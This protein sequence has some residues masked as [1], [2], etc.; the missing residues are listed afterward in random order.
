MAIAAF[1]LAGGKSSRM[2]TDKGLLEYKNKPMIAH[3]IDA[4]EPITKDIS[5]ITGNNDYKK[6]NKPLISD[7]IPEKGPM[8][9]VYTALKRCPGSHALILTCDTPLI[10][11][12]LINILLED[13]KSFEATYFSFGYKNYPLTAVYKK[14]VNNIFFNF[15][16]S[17]NLKMNN[18]LQVLTSN[19]IYLNNTEG[20]LL[21][22]I[23][24]PEQ[25]KNIK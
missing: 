22:N 9:G 17:N 15:I 14:E 1:I 21:A 7:I 3:V 24:T 23:N 8:G 2:G 5:I 25:L 20:K 6:F 12:H 4:V 19:R 18:I 13:Y 11:T 16:S 10:N